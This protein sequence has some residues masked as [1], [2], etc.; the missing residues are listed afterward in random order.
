MICDNAQ[1]RIAQLFPSGPGKATKKV[2]M[3]TLRRIFRQ[4]M[5]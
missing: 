2:V 4:G 1:A 5:L 3:L